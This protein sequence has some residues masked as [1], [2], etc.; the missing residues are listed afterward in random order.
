MAEE[1]VHFT[2]DGKPLVIDLNRK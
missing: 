2:W 1:T